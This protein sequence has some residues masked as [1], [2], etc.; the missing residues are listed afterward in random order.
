MR[1]DPALERYQVDALALFVSGPRK[2]D[3]AA[4]QRSPYANLIR[5]DLLGK[6][7]GH[8]EALY[9]LTEAGRAAIRECVEYVQVRGTPSEDT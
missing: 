5:R 9:A 1:L 8:G 2:I 3:Q 7:G 4:R 6:V